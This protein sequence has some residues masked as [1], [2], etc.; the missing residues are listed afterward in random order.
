MQR[1][2]QQRDGIGLSG[3]LV[4]EVRSAFT[5]TG[6]PAGRRGRLLRR[7]R[8]PNTILNGAKQAVRDY[9]STGDPAITAPT[10]PTHLAF[11]TDATAADATQTALVAE[12]FRSLLASRVRT[13]LQIVFKHFLTD[14]E[15]NGNTLREWGLVNA[16]AGGTFFTRALLGS[17]IAKT[18]SITVTSTW[19]V[20][21]T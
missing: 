8:Q 13:G 9:W 18:S 12:A 3:E 20:T 5:R 16:A 4:V 15:A 6:R 21:I 10:A 14:V 2:V 7:I 11:G 1:R 19:T 17:P